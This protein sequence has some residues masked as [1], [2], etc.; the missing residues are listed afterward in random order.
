MPDRRRK[1]SPTASN[2]S[3]GEVA[4]LAKRALAVVASHAQTDALDLRRARYN[5][6]CDALVDVD[7]AR[8]HNVIARLIA[9]GVS[10]DEIYECYLPQAARMLGQRWVDDE[11]SFA[12]VSVGASRLQNLARGLSARYESGGKTIPLG[13]TA[14]I[15]VPQSEQHTFGAFIAASN[16]RRHGLWVHMA[17]DMSNTEIVETLRAHSFSMVGISASSERSLPYVRDL[18]DEIRAS[19]APQAPLV[20]GGAVTQLD[21]D[22]QSA[23]GADLVSTNTREVLDF[24]G[25]NA[26]QTS[27]S[28]AR[29]VS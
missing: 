4:A 5:E 6:L 14:L 26:Q 2:L 7:E 9:F 12:Q 29:L 24:C 27:L 18:I 25:L 11:L 3:T 21:I 23:T 20:V 15:V 1:T 10:S 22:V 8:R 17:L 16:F 19:D 13:H 28:P